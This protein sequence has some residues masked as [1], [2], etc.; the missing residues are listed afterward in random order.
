MSKYKIVIEFETD[1]MV[2]HDVMEELSEVCLIQLESLSDGDLE[3]QGHRI[4]YS[5]AGVNW[6][7]VEE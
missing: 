6:V 7:K 4:Q 5:N 1:E 3:T 2:P